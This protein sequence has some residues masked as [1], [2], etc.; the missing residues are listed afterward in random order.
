ME[1]RRNVTGR[2][3]RS[4]LISE[5]RGR[6][7]VRPFSSPGNASKP[8]TAHQFGVPDVGT[9]HIQSRL[10][11]KV[12]EVIGALVVRLVEPGERL[13]QVVH[14][15]V[16]VTPCTTPAR[17]AAATSP[18]RLERWRRAFSWRPVIPIASP[19]DTWS[20]PS[21][22]TEPEHAAA[23]TRWRLEDARTPRSTVRAP[24]HASGLVRAT[25]SPGCTDIP[26]NEVAKG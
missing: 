18:W 20:C 6:L 26:V 15:S 3:F 7:A 24:S 17:T 12:D 22:I 14:A 9:Q 13:I 16:N 11:T 2:F 21:S 25:S 19:P 5:A 10:D 23:A 1:G 4:Y 8:D